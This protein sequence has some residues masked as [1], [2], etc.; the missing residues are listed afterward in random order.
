VS[1]RFDP[2]YQMSNRAMIGGDGQIAS[3]ELGTVMRSLGQNPTETELREMIDEVD[4]D[5][6]GSFDF[7]EF[8]ATFTRKMRDVD[9]E[10][11]N[12]EAFKVFDNDGNGYISPAELMHIMTNLGKRSLWS[13][14]GSC[15]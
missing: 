1:Q 7:P 3:K 4:T 15:S 8:L 2:L 9:I 10:E 11:E 5:G 13:S 12:K 6:K 14:M